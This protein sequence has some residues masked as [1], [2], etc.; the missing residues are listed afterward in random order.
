MARTSTVAL[1]AR[2]ARGALL[3]THAARPPTVVLPLRAHMTTQSHTLD[4]SNTPEPLV[5]S[6]QRVSRA[7]KD[8]VASHPLSPSAP[9]PAAPERQPTP[10]ARVHVVAKQLTPS[11]RHL[12]PLLH[13]QPSHY[14]T[15][16]IHGRPYLVTAGDTLRL[17]FLMPHVKPGDVL[18]LNRATHIGSRDYTLKAP[19]PLKGTADHGKKVFYLDERLFTARARVVGIE[20]EPMRV[21]EKTKR[22]QRHTKHVFS[23]MR[24]TVLKISHLEVRSLDEYERVLNH[25]DGEA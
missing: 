23:K 4:A 6:G 25:K 22:R 2:T 21:E 15:L 17:P 19:E 9:R 24:F 11:I 5:Q 20:T 14:M 12:L 16:H 18:R 7:L 10:N 8:K 13:A 1:L 3:E